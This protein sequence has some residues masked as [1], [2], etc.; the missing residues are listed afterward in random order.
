[1]L[2]LSSGVACSVADWGGVP[3]RINV[4]FTLVGLGY[5]STTVGRVVVSGRMNKINESTEHARTHIPPRPYRRTYTYLLRDEGLDPCTKSIELGT[6]D[7]TLG[8]SE[9]W[10]TGVWVVSAR[11]G[12]ERRRKEEERGRRKGEREK[13]G[14]REE[15]EGRRRKEKEGVP[16]SAKK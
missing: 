4:N 8:G 9:G 16:R 2:R 14:R 1:M 12:E 13:R 5:L 10:E 11:L 3:V 15:G 7:V 6:N